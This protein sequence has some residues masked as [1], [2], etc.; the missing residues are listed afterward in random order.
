MNWANRIRSQKAEVR[1]Q[2][3]GGITAFARWAVFESVRHVI[4]EV[5]AAGGNI[6]PGVAKEYEEWK[7]KV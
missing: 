1:R 6:P 4:T 5:A 3:D 2:N 7:S